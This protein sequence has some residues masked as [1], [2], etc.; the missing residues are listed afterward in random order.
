MLVCEFI[1]KEGLTEDSVVYLKGAKSG[2]N[3]K[4]IFPRSHYVIHDANTNE[5]I[6]FL[7]KYYSLDETHY[8]EVRKIIIDMVYETVD[9]LLS[10]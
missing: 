4:P 5:M 7:D 1:H 9:E 10:E 2:W 6:T 3:K 8:R